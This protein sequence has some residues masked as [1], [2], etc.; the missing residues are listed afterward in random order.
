M[1]KSASNNLKRY[2]QST[3]LINSDHPDVKAK[4]S[5]ITRNASNPEERAR[6]IFYFIRDSIPYEFR[7]QLHENAYL[8]SSILKAGKGFCTQKAILFCALARSASIPAGIH[9]YDIEDHTLRKEVAAFLRTKTLF[10]HG[11]AALYLQ[12]DWHLYDA[13]LDRDLA[14]RKKIRPVAFYPDRDCL[15]IGPDPASPPQ[16]EYRKDYGMVDDVTFAD[17][18][19]WLRTGYPHLTEGRSGRQSPDPFHSTR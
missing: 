3:P 16:I 5:E 14:E 4:Q 18:L 9:F 1:N 6:S 19:L 10:H 17:I 12:E 13:T 7:A 15:M 2:L 8:A 11:I